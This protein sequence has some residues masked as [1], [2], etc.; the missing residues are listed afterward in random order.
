MD[1]NCR[2]CA[3]HLVISD[4]NAGDVREVR[5]QLKLSNY[6]MEMAAGN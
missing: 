5:V 2:I 1:E 6:K 4:V 3:V